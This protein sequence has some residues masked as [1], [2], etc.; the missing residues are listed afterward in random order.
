M[1][2]SSTHNGLEIINK[3]LNLLNILIESTY[4]CFT[5]V[6]LMDYASRN[7]AD[8]IQN[9]NHL[10]EEITSGFKDIFTVINAS[11]SSIAITVNEKLKLPTAFPLL[12]MSIPS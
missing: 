10:Q 7:F 5:Q 12:G 4:K 6:D 3:K 2:F 1:L 11:R 9:S 8:N